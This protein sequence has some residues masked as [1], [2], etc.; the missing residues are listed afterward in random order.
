MTCKWWYS[1]NGHVAKV[2]GKGDCKSRPL[3]MSFQV[4][5]LYR[6]ILLLHFTQTCVHVWAQ[7]NIHCAHFALSCTVSAPIDDGSKK[8]NRASQF[9]NTFGRIPSPTHLQPTSHCLSKVDLLQLSFPRPP[10][11]PRSSMWSHLTSPTTLRSV[12][13]SSI[14]CTCTVSALD[15]R[16]SQWILPSA[17]ATTSPD[18]ASRSNQPR[19]L[20]AVPSLSGGCSKRP[21]LRRVASWFAVVG[22]VT[23][24]HFG[25]DSRLVIL[26]SASIRMRESFDSNP[27]VFAKG[28]A[29]D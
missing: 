11:Q 14:A 8:K 28:S 18:T 10:A 3:A 27:I 19:A 7:E 26:F 2:P 29:H 17:E 21:T 20:H 9:Y 23:L 12:L 25:C 4:V 15:P 5:V 16:L 24:L 13:V 6:H 1:P 22:A